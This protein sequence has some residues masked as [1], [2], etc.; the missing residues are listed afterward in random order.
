LSTPAD[1]LTTTSYAILGLLAIKPWSTYELAQQMR[2][3]L[4]YFWP[5]AESNLYAEPKR[6]VDGGYAR[7]EAHP[8][9]KRRRTVYVITA[10]GRKALERWL[11]QPAAAARLESEGLVKL[12]LAPN[13]SKESLLGHL[14]GLREE[15]EARRRELHSILRPY[16]EG[17][18]PFPDRLHVTV[19]GAR[20]L[21]DQARA[22]IDW[23]TWAL[24][25]A[26]RWP[27]TQAP[28]DA[29]HLLRLLENALALRPPGS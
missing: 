29:G 19:L 8:H 5:R 4:H 2:R 16:L 28:N 11:D 24:S 1:E 9:G 27:D 13:S 3:D 6:L 22:Q 7:S 18:G 12:F 15:A 20:L 10:K 25:E 17:D 26:E 14:R 21:L 23:A